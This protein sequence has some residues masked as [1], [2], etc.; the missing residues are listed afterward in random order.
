GAYLH[1]PSGVAIGLFPDLPAE[2]FIQVGN[3]AGDGVRQ[4][5]ASTR[6]RTRART[7]SARCRYVE[8]SKIGNFQKTFLYRIAFN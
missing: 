7:L 8:L 4:M 1:V 6:A 5:L 2:R 3:A